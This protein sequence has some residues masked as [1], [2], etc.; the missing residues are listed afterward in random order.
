MSFIRFGKRIKNRSFDYVPRYYDQEKEELEKRMKRYR[1][2]PGDTELSKE[3]IRG[4]FRKTYRVKDDY[5]S[6]TKKRSNLILL[7]TLIILIFLTYI[8]L[9]DYLPKIIQAFEQ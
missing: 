2:K 7:A 8:F 4:G 5:T 3:R 9:M 1:S 6:R